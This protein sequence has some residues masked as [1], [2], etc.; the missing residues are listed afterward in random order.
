[1]KCSQKIN[2]LGNNTECRD[3]IL[4]E[5]KVKV[6]EAG[7]SVIRIPKKNFPF[8]KSKFAGSAKKALRKLS[9]RRSFFFFFLI[10]AKIFMSVYVTLEQL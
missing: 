9:V 7:T 5:K 2:F 10:K 4:H 1:M 6:S 8:I 3:L